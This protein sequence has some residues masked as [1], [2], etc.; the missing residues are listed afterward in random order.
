MKQYLGKISACAHAWAHA[1]QP[2]G[3]SSHVYFEGNTIYSYGS[4]FP[5]ATIVGDLVFFTLKKYS[6][7]TAQH[8]AIA[9]SAV[10]HKKVVYVAWVPVG[11]HIL[12]DKEFYRHNINYWVT[13]LRASL[14]ILKLSPR[15]K[16]EHFNISTNLAML[17]EFITATEFQV[18][19]TLR[20]FLNCPTLDG[21]KAFMQNENRH[22]R[23][24][25]NRRMAKARR[26]YAEKVAEWKNASIS[27]LPLCP[28][29]LNEYTFLRFNPLNDRVE[30]SKQVELP[31]EK[32]R[33]FWEFI[34]NVLQSGCKSFNYSIL[35]F[36][37]DEITKDYIKVGCH[38]IQIS[39]A[40][41]IA[42]LLN[43]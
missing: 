19:K 27:R 16:S 20:E 3:R 9:L 36:K 31:V 1:L 12:K 8:K 41:R 42:E 34:K 15:T 33:H 39:E 22:K 2:S 17:Q 26:I 43:W 23:A 14:T 6:P 4:H 21:V 38:K 11:N 13:E 35:H 5:I 32:A 25:E 10:S 7:T 30:T 28:A 37:V 18:G 24:A 40:R 29:S